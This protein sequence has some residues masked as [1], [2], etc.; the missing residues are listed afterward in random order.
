[1]EN[2][3]V[4]DRTTKYLRKH[5]SVDIRWFL[6]D[7]EHG[8]D[9]AKNDRELDIIVQGILA[10]PWYVIYSGHNKDDIS[11]KYNPLSR[12]SFYIGFIGGAVGLIGGILGIISFFS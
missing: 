1:M 3:E 9:I 7:K 2:R 6:K 8:L 4:I 11:I 5:K 12:L 10:Y